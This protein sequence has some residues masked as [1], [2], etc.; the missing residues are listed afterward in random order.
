MT[1]EPG[2]S[3]LYF[4]GVCNLCS[5]VVQFF[6]RHDH[7][8]RFLFASL[9]SP[10]G[11]EALNN[12]EHATGKRPD[13]VLLFHEGKYYL[14]STAVLKALSL[15]GGVWSL[16]PSLLIV[17]GIFRDGIYNWVAKNRYKWFGKQDACMIPTP[18]LQSRFLS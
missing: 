15:L 16:S 6:I 17:P 11:V 13:S 10:A 18:E 7:K 3:V 8:K 2:R 12:A 4:D 5:G 1:I 14:Q 9:Q